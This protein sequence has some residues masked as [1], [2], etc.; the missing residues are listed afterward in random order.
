MKIPTA[1]SGSVQSDAIASLKSFTNMITKTPT[2]VTASGINVVTAFISTSL[3]EFTSP[4]ILARIFPL[5]IPSK[6]EKESVWICSYISCLIFIRISFDIFD[7]TYILTL[8]N[9][10]KSRLSTSATAPSIS[11]PSTS[12]AAT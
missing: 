9:T 5:G 10:I 11:S 6:K 4:I 7:I 1:S 2:I 3:S 12:P 8:A